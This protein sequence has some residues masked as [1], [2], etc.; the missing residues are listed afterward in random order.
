MESVE[1]RDF[2]D[3]DLDWVLNA[4]VESLTATLTPERL[5]VSEPASL[6]NDA[7]KDFD[8]FHYHTQKPDKAILAWRGGRRIGFVWITM[9]MPVHE[10][11]KSAWLLDVYVV[12]ELR[13]QG[14]A[15]DLM[16]KAEEWAVSQG[17]KEVWL[18]VGGGNQKALSLYES[19][20]FH[21]ETMHLCKK[22]AT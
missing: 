22:L 19:Q 21:V 17:A 1:F 7:R 10:D 12:P 20:G 4:M 6:M 14:L 3:G 5:A 18:N 9:N 11:E 15:R 16:R 2:E 8:R 13:G